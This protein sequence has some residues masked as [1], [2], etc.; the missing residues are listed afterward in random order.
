MV[1]CF[2]SISSCQSYFK[3]T[4][5]HC[6]IEQNKRSILFHHYV[7]FLFAEHHNCFNKMLF[8]FLFL[9]CI[10]PTQ[11]IIIIIIFCIARS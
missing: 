2:K 7:S 11:F 3:Y 8:L 9:I 1:L 10:L 4:Y 5:S 6:C